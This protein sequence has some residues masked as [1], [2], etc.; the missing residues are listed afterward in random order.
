M[1][2]A[3]PANNTR[4]CTQATEPWS[5]TRIRTQFTKIKSITQTVHAAT[6]NAAIV[7]LENDVHQ[8]LVVMDTD[9]GKLLIYIQLMRNPKFKKIGSCPQQTNLE[10]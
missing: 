9:T 3:A 5:R 6:V 7:Q 4:L 8:D 1:H 10:G 2:T